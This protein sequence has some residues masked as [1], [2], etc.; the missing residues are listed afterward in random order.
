MG[1]GLTDFVQPLGN[2]AIAKDDDLL[3]SYRSVANAADRNAIPAERRKVGM[4]VRTNDTQETWVLGPGITNSDW[5]LASF[6]KGGPFFVAS[7][8][9]RNAIPHE[10]REP[11]AR[12]FVNTNPGRVYILKQTPWADDDTDWIDGGTDA[13]PYVQ[14]VTMASPVTVDYF[15][16][17]G[18]FLSRPE[19]VLLVQSGTGGPTDLAVTLGTPVENTR[20]TVVDIDG[21]LNNSDP[22]RILLNG[23]FLGGATPVVLDTP[24]RNVSL[25]FTGGAWT[26]LSDAIDWQT[27]WSENGGPYINASTGLDTNDGLIGTPLLTWA[28]FFRRFGSALRYSFAINISGAIG[29]VS[30]AFDCGGNQLLI[31][32]TPTVVDTDVVLSHTGNGA[33]D[34]A[35]TV[36]TRTSGTFNVA[37]VGKRIRLTTGPANV[38]YI[39]DVSGATATIS[40]PMYAPN[41]QTFVVEDDVDSVDLGPVTVSPD[42]SRL[43]DGN[44]PAV[45]FIRLHVNSGGGLESSGIGFDNCTFELVGAPLN[46]NMRFTAKESLFPA[47]KFDIGAS[48]HLSRC[49]FYSPDWLAMTQD[50]RVDCASEEPIS[51]DEVEFLGARLVVYPESGPVKGKNLGA[52]NSW[53]DGFELQDGARLSAYWLYGSGNGVSGAGYGLSVVHGARCRFEAS[54]VGKV[55]A[56]TAELR[57]DEVA[58]S[59]NDW[60][61]NITQPNRLL[62][63]QTLAIIDGTYVGQDVGLLRKGQRLR[64]A[65]TATSGTVIPRS[66]DLIFT[67]SSGGPFALALPSPSSMGTVHYEFTFV[68]INGSAAAN[69]VTIAT[70]STDLISGAATYVLSN[71]Y[72]SVTVVWNGTN[73]SVL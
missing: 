25:L 35:M 54:T 52:F 19:I 17:T 7:T 38:S 72:E 53:L 47:V 49:V 4:L 1:V 51:F 14:T 70:Q 9:A 2:F 32:G 62:V 29:D 60:L 6:G 68:D 31:I 5:T 3:G 12:C 16:G 45:R 71:N 20:L 23:S 65:F 57:I 36:L 58:Y 55:T 21:A 48:A 67:D 69:N 8:T 18:G 66:F 15:V 10:V 34:N 30:G 33:G 27:F 39:V 64:A 63:S 41:G 73:W 56:A 42:R 13:A 40:P 24:Y 26:V 37:H 11:G 43:G 44:A 46:I 50:A 28:E 22:N 61:G 59:W